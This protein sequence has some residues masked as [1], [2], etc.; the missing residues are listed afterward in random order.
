MLGESTEM[1]ISDLCGEIKAQVKMPN[2]SSKCLRF[3][4]AVRKWK[5]ELQHASGGGK[6]DPTK[7]VIISEMEQLQ[8]ALTQ[9]QETVESVLGNALIKLEE[10]AEGVVT[11]SAF[12]C[13][14]YVR[15]GML[16]VDV[17][18]RTATKKLENMKKPT[19]TQ[20]STHSHK[21]KNV[22]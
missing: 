3:K 13:D 18:L 8:S 9:M 15:L 7:T 12:F 6:S 1:D 17:C 22:R 4:K 21:S 19:H 20:K 5:L 16:F 2:S 14:F 10:T 11:H